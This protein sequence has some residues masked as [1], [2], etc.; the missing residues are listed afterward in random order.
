MRPNG[1][2]PSRRLVSV[3]LTA[4]VIALMLG[5]SASGQLPTED[6]SGD[7]SDDLYGT[8]TGTVS[9]ADTGDACEGATVT[10][11]YHGI[12][13]EDTTD[14]E[15]RY[16]FNSVPICFCLKTV[17]ALKDGYETQSLD[18]GVSKMTVVD[19]QLVPDGGDDPYGGTVTGTVTDAETGQPIEG[20]LVRITH[21]G[22]VSEALTDEDGR[23][24]VTGI[25][26]CYCLKDISVSAEGY[27]GQEDQ[28][29]VGEETVADFQLEPDDGS[30][31]IAPVMPIRKAPGSMLER[32]YIMAGLVAAFVGLAAVGYYP[33]MARE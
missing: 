20:A 25:P 24:T 2:R 14:D 33:F 27:E 12:L 21:H 3:L 17:T 6:G 32:P 16:T 22:E 13:R 30:G 7:G 10:I 8:V 4:S 26:L 31:S 11:E 19:F 1:K 18:V 9:D 29:A 5:M 28:I 15:G 23:Y